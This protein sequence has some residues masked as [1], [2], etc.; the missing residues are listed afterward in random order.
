MCCLCVTGRFVW[1]FDWLF[2]LRVYGLMVNSVD[3]ALYCA[4]WFVWLREFRGWFL[5][6]IAWC[7]TVL[8]VVV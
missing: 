3:I 2:W 4:V 8:V 1:V 7:F 5:W 6:V